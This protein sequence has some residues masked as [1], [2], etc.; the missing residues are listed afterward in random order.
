MLPW[1][2]FGCAEQPM[3]ARPKIG[4]GRPDRLR[5]G[6]PAASLLDRQRVRKPQPVR[7]AHKG[8]MASSARQAVLGEPEFDVLRSLV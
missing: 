6:R 8:R 3:P 4:G 1:T 5:V 7:F 2:F